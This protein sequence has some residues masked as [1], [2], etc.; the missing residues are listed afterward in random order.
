MSQAVQKSLERLE[1]LLGPDAV[2]TGRAERF[3]VST[4]LWPRHLLRWRSGGPRITPVAV[5][6]PTSIEALVAVVKEARKVGYEL[7]PYGAGSSVV[8]GATPEPGQVVVDLK[9][10]DSIRAVDTER[11]MVHAEAGVNGE[12]LDREL[13]RQGWT[14][15]HYPSS[16]YCSTVGGWIAARGAGQFSSRYGKIEDQVLGARV[17]T[18]QGKILEFEPNVMRSHELDQW[19]GNEG[20]MGFWVDAWMRIRPLPEERAWDA[21]DFPD[22]KQPSPAHAHG[23]RQA[24]R[25]RYFESTTRSIRF[26]IKMRTTVKQKAIKGRAAWLGW[27][28]ISRS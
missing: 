27:G 16:I 9:R 21:F 26:F 18:G 2:I 14:Q 10:L 11:W 19:I 17:V 22:L 13:K 5:I 15:G 28:R 6:E 1:G 24:S 12:V 20:R 8:G 25:R 3:A 7:V 23:L 4:D